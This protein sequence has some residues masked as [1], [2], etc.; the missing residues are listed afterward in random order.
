[1]K[2]ISKLSLFF[3]AV[4]FSVCSLIG[5][6]PQEY[7]SYISSLMLK[8]ST[9]IYND[10][11]KGIHN[12]SISRKSNFQELCT[13]YN[14]D[15]EKVVTQLMPMG[16]GR[17][18]HDRFYYISDSKGDIITVKDPLAKYIYDS[19]DNLIKMIIKCEKCGAKLSSTGKV[20]ETHNKSHYYDHLAMTHYKQ[21]IEEHLK[22][23]ISLAK[24]DC[25][26]CADAF[27]LSENLYREQLRQIT[28][29]AARHIN[30]LPEND[31]S[32]HVYC[33][34]PESMKKSYD[35]NK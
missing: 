8:A 10:Q 1:M 15:G 29:H 22:E 17:P 6:T 24:G 9:A 25:S 32:G 14:E 18:K 20:H 2:Q 11:E 33:E 23:I 3:G 34:T 27:S 31:L 19:N 16:F 35:N 30:F 4:L 5:M 26:K 21:Y 7:E 13:Y 28:I 12:P